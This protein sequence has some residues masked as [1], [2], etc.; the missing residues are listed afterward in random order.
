VKTLHTLGSVAV[1]AATLA[2]SACGSS[3]SDSGIDTGGTTGPV[4][5][6]QPVQG[7]P[8]PAGVGASGAAFLA[9]LRGLSGT[10]ETSEPF[11]IPDSFAVPD[12]EANDPSTVT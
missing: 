5:G 1:L 3:S 10:D 8:L 4:S 6:A 11:S 12:D 2:L 9:Y 7:A